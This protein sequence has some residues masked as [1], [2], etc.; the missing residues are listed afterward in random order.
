V[1]R[2][3]VELVR[4]SY[5]TFLSG[6]IDAALGFFDPAG[7]FVSRFGVME[8]RTYKGYDGIRQYL[9]DIE[10]AWESYEREFVDLVDA[11]EAVLAIV[12]VKAVS[13]GSAVPV[14]ERIGLAYWLRGGRIVRMVS[15]PT[16]DEA[17]RAVGLRKG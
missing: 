14:Q 3:D 7:E 1:S 12:D 10:E 2:E 11:G 8:G 15:Y 6:D 5:E 13:K 16:V 9:T 17:L 4:R